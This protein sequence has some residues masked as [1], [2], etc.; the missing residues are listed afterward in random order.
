MSAPSDQ[1][2]RA[3]SLKLGDQLARFPGGG[4]GFESVQD[5][6]G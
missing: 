4:G 1:A 2:G 3:E 6:A 5:F